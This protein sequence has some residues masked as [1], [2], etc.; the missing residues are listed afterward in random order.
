MKPGAFNINLLSPHLFWD[1]DVRKITFKDNKQFVIKR[2]LE[3]G[4][5]SD[6]MQLCNH[7]KINEIADAVSNVKD[8]DCKSL[9]FIASI[10]KRPKEHFLC[11]TTKQSTISHSPF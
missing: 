6:W 3:Y 1:V 7:L 5:L 11:Y 4:L 2:I 8:M 9:S 10:S